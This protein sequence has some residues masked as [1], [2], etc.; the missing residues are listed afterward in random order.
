DVAEL[1]RALD[2]LLLPSEEEPFG[3]ALI[4]AMALGVPVLATN[5]GGPAEIIDD[6]VEGYLLAPHDPP[7]WAQ[8]IRRIAASADRG[9][10]MGQAGR[11]RVEREFTS[12]RH[13]AATL[14]SYERAIARAG[15]RPAAKVHA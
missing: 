7:A 15:Q 11:R 6:G 8:A 3:R 13:V 2:I 4:E 10:A 12:E 14:A 5:V 9:A 1:M